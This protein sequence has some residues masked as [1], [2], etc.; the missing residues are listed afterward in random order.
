MKTFTFE[1]NLLIDFFKKS[2]LIP[3]KIRKTFEF[4]LSTAIND[5]VSVFN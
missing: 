1:F 4:N 5:Q 3:V 2:T